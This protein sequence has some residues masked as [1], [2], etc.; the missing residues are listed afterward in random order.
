VSAVKVELCLPI[1]LQDDA[2]AVTTAKIITVDSGAI[3]AATLLTTDDRNE[4][5]PVSSHRS[6]IKIFIEPGSVFETGDTNQTAWTGFTGSIRPPRQTHTREPIVEALGTDAVSLSIGIDDFLRLQNGKTMFVLIESTLPNRMDDPVVYH[7]SPAGDLS[8]AG[9]DGEWRGLVL[10]QGGTVLAKRT[11]TPEEG[12]TTYTIGLLLASMSDYAI[13][14]N[15]FE[16][17]DTS[18][19]SNNDQYSSCF[20]KTLRIENTMILHGIIIFVMI[21]LAFFIYFKRQFR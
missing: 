13:G 2:G 20:I 4:V 9:V 7:V 11:N 10:R 15:L 14:S 8:L 21:G 17:P 6:R 12:L 18:L 1:A 3:P 5:S 16:T 19:D